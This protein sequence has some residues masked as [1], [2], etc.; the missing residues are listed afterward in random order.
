MAIDNFKGLDHRLNLVRTLH[1][2][3]YFNDSKATNVDAVCRALEGL[4][5]PLILIMGGRDKG[6][7]YQALEAQIADKVRSLVVMG[8]AADNITAALGHLVPTERATDMAAAVRLA[9]GQARSG[10]VVLLSPAC[11]SFDMYNSYHQRGEDFCRNVRQ[12]T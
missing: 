3:R 11:A 2:V 1:G 12:L 8:E 9:A 5:A 4:D 10:D 6:G 7:S